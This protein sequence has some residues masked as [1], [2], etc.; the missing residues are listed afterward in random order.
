MNPRVHSRANSLSSC[1]LVSAGGRMCKTFTSRTKKASGSTEGGI[2]HCR[3]TV[4]AHI[5]AAA[6]QARAGLFGINKEGFDRCGGK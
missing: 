2:A 3:H 4:S 6:N 1:G 5:T